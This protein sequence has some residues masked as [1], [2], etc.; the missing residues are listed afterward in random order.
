M[1]A[2][3]A[4]NY[5]L[6]LSKISEHSMLIPILQN[7]QSKDTCLSNFYKS[8]AKH[9]SN[10]S[11]RNILWF[12]AG[13]NYYNKILESLTITESIGFSLRFLNDSE[14]KLHLKKLIIKG[15]DEGYLETLIISGFDSETPGLL[16]KYYER[17]SD[18]QTVGIVSVFAQQFIRSDVLDNFVFGYKSQLNRLE[19]YNLRC[20]FEIEESKLLNKKVGQGKC[21]RCYYCGN[22]TAAC[23]IT[24]SLAIARRGDP[25][26]VSKPY[27]N[28]CPSCPYSLPKCCVCLNNIKSLNPHFIGEK[29]K[30]GII[31][32][33]LL[34]W[35]EK[36]HHGGHTSHLIEWFNEN[37]EC[38][39][40]NCG[41]SCKALDLL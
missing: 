5:E 21:I 22:S 7:I 39:V 24:T 40:N 12:L 2:I 41:C 16:T 3:F 15:Y 13:S 38:A 23:E 32:I 10:P 35:C 6:A 26:S 31:Y 30:G 4:F 14:L 18:L 20:E 8:V 9:E 1:Y 29:G 36:C 27:L 11:T 37:N 33:E 25:H 34:T 19:L 17:T 28:H